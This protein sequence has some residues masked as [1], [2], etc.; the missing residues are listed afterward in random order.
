MLSKMRA[1]ANLVI[2]LSLVVELADVIAGVAAG[3]FILLYVIARHDYGEIPSI[4]G[5]TLPS[6][7]ILAFVVWL[8]F[9][10]RKSVRVIRQQRQQPAAV[11]RD[12][13]E[14]ADPVS[15]PNSQGK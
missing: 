4:L 5:D 14:S 12:E 3:G 13:G 10:V 15:D 8:Y 6:L 11:A 7:A 1:F 2:R 9:A